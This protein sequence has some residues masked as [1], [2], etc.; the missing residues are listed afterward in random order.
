MTSRHRV[1][2]F[3]STMLGATLLAAVLLAN[4]AVPARADVNLCL[5]CCGNTSLIYQCYET[6][7]TC[8]EI[9]IGPIIRDCEQLSVA[10]GGGSGGSG[11]VG[12]LHPEVDGQSLVGVSSYQGDATGPSGALSDFVVLW[13]TRDTFEIGRRCQAVA[14]GALFRA[15]FD[16]AG[17]DR[18]AIGDLV[19]TGTP[20]GE[21]VRA[22][23]D[24]APTGR[25]AGGDMTVSVYVV[26]QNDPPTAGQAPLAKATVLE[27]HHTDIV[28]DDLQWSFLADGPV[29]TETTGWGTLKAE[30][31]R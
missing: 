8:D 14:G 27:V 2:L 9:E 24:L 3:V 23:F 16:V 1:P 7:I 18:R 22:A 12:G 21:E 11:V 15:E 10:P 26:V 30:Y 19:I 6:E 25:I 29:A 28:F 31:R 5:N 20:A 13:E 17:G 4:L